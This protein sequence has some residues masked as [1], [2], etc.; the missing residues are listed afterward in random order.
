MLAS[1][2]WLKRYVPEFD[3]H[4][5]D[6][7][8]NKL[9]TRLSEVEEVKVVGEGLSGLV[10]AEI[11][12]A[13]PHPTNPKLQI[14]QVNV[15][16]EGVFNVVCGAPNARA[17][18][19]T[20]MCLPGG[21]VFNPD[22]HTE[23]VEIGERK[24][25]D[26][27]SQGMLCSPAELGLSN[28]HDGIIELPSGSKVGEEVD[29]L[30]K[31]IIIEIENKSLPHRPDV[32]SHLGLAREIAAIFKI[33]IQASQPEPAH[34]PSEQSLEMLVKN[35]APDLCRR[36]SGI[37]IT[38][39]KI[40]PS[41]LWL[42]IALS[43]AGIRPINNIVDIT[44]YVMLDIGQPLHAF[45]MDKLVGR[46]VFIRLSRSG[47]KIVTLDKVDRELPEKTV[48]IANRSDAI[49]IAGIM[50]GFSTMIEN[51][52]TNVFIESANFEM[53]SIRRSSRALGLRTDASSRFE[54]GLDPQNTVVALLKAVSM[55]TDITD[56]E[57][58]SGIVDSYTSPEQ[59]NIIEFNL[60]DVRRL[61][62]IEINKSE[63]LDILESLGIT[64]HGADQI[65]R[66]ALMRQ[67]LDSELSLEIPSYRR[68]LR[69]SEDIV[70]EIARL[71]SYENILPTLPKR[72]LAAPSVNKF[73][74]LSLQIKRALAYSGLYE[75][76]TYSMVGSD[77]Y[78]NALLNPKSL[79]AL[80][81]P[82]S[83]ELAKIRDD[84]VPSLLDKLQ[85]NMAKFD[86][87]GLFELSRVAI[88]DKVKDGLPLQPHKAAAVLIDENDEL[89][90]RRLKTAIENMSHMLF[91]NKLTIQ[92]L[93]SQKG[94]HA[95]FHP[96][97]TGTI[98]LNSE[99]VGSIGIAHPQVVKNF[100]IT[101]SSV[102]ILTL[103][104]DTIM[105]QQLDV[106]QFIP[107]SNYQPVR[108]DLSFWQKEGTHLDDIV[109]N[110]EKLDD[111]LL[112]Q[113]DIIDVFKREGKTSF[114]LRIILQSSDHTLTQAEIDQRI[115]G[116]VDTIKKLGHELR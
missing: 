22:N 17:G 31:D 65:S 33:N 60:N 25:Q 13:S 89:A 107:V 101:S 92:P 29:D 93:I 79:L 8:K 50:G 62:G 12:D 69:I 40:E 35:N 75:I 49:A 99:V 10:V 46:Q 82:I 81:N 102:S 108:R 110:V 36:Y 66:E 70:E 4:D 38:N 54:K 24:F 48:V 20:V 58:A 43:Y 114:T 30:F 74:E 67:D 5:L 51:H 104:L 84:I 115:G 52:T 85:P 88:G 16:N 28:S 11:I 53:Y 96:G 32:F 98:L 1:L 56:G 39:V 14:C 63:I 47:E 41:P 68:D 73:N 94:L 18:L 113:S 37:S 95:Y 106:T 55:I 87:F 64:T 42:Q 57:V 109:R 6:K 44:N 34:K 91:K 76:Y 97:K 72:S 27:T 7:F 9:D 2:K 3:I 59:P 90:Y 86:K 71:N 105:E 21:K 116:V 112:Q 77:L 61:A 26:T 103:D 83:P 100:G 15:G 78:N 23:L 80:P 45:D 111:Q 19:Y